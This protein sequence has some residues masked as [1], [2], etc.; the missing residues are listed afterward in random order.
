MFSERSRAPNVT[1]TQIKHTAYL[2][3]TLIGSYSVP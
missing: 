3:N 2:E 1:H